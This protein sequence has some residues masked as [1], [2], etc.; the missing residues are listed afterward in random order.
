MGVGERIV[1]SR[2]AGD[3]IEIPDGVDLLQKQWERRTAMQGNGGLASLLAERR[4][5]F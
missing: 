3:L 1:A 2:E 4:G 5:R